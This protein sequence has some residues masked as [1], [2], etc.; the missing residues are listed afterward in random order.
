MK[1]PECVC[2]ELLSV[3]R[4]PFAAEIGSITVHQKKGAYSTNMAQNH[5]NTHVHS[6]LPWARRIMIV[7]VIL[8]TYLR[9]LIAW[10]SRMENR[11]HRHQ[12]QST[13]HHTPTYPT[14]PFASLVHGWRRL[15]AA[16]GEFTIGEQ[17]ELARLFNFVF[18]L[19]V[20]SQTRFRMNRFRCANAHTISVAAGRKIA[21]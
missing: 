20:C 2:Y 16:G 11:N 18:F 15:A 8:T 7:S 19:C 9:H 5:G 13:S 21:V 17:G 4:T 10:L 14:P 12:Q 1:C 3:K 6:Q